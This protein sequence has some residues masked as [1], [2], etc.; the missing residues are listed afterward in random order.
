MFCLRQKSILTAILCQNASDRGLS[1]HPNL[2]QL[3]CLDILKLPVGTQHSELTTDLLPHTFKAHCLF[4][5]SYGDLNRAARLLARDS[6]LI[7]FRNSFNANC[8]VGRYIQSNNS[9]SQTSC[10]KWRGYWSEEM[11]LI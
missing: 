3:A 9:T 10:C 11:V 5:S 6:L 2:P 8:H 7:E 4:W 1:I